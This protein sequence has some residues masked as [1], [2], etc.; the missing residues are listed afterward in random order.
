MRAIILAA[1]VGKRLSKFTHKPKSLLKINNETLITRIIRLLNEHDIRD[2]VVVTGFKQGLLKSEI[3]KCGRKV[4][5]IHNSLFKKGSIISLWKAAGYFNKDILIMDADLFFERALIKKVVDSEKKDFFL[6]DSSNKVDNEAV[7]VGFKRSRAVKLER[8]LKGKYSPIGE[9]AGFLKLSRNS[10]KYLK[11]ILGDLIN[12]GDEDSGYEFIIPRLF[13]KVNISYE[14]I[15]GLK[16]VEIDFPKDVVKAK[17][18][19]IIE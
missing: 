5:F 2:I 14:L 7:I 13:N 12:N 9:W 15:D 8:G 11:K 16:W 1:G 4:K 18:L 6:I 19:R 17:G 3:S 10:A